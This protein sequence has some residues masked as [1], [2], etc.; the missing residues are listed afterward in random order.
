[1]D[2]RVTPPTAVS[3]VGLC[4]S[5]G[6][7]AVLD[8]IDLHVAEGTIFALLGPNGSGKTTT[9]NILSTLIMADGGE[10]RVA[11]HD[12]ARDADAVRAGVGQSVAVFASHGRI[13]GIHAGTARR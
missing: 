1:M 8:R 4:K 7:K 13:R 5:F 11:G 6:D 10:V 12:V 3:A 9:V 2:Q